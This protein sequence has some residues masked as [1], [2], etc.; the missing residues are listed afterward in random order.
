MIR[1]LSVS[2]SR[3]DIG[4]LFPIWQS[5]LSF[6]KVELHLLMTGMHQTE[7]A[8]PDID[9]PT[10]VKVHFGGADL[11]GA[12][13]KVAAAAMAS[14]TNATADL[15]AATKPDV[16]LVVGDRLDML[17]AAMASLPFNLPMVHL[18][19]GEV[20]E[21]A[22]DN[23]IRHAISK[24][25]HWHCVATNGARKFLLAIGENADRIT[26]TGAPGLD[27]LQAAPRISKANFLRSTGLP[28]SAD[29]WLV[30]VHAETNSPNPLLPIQAV[31][32]ALTERPAPVLFTAPNSDPGGSYIR[33]QIKEFCTTRNDLI[34]IDTLGSDLY[35]NALRHAALMLGNSS[36]GIIE[37]GLFGLP[38]INVGDRQLGRESD[39]NVFNV[40]SEG[41]AIIAALD[42]LKANPKRFRNQSIYGDGK[43]GP[44][45][46][47]IL[48]ELNGL[49]N[50]LKKTASIQ[51]SMP[52]S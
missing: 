46:A 13:G 36:S 51:K 38:V 14:I 45:V 41:S 47:E 42:K 43:S 25:A 22:V 4:I 31:L 32:K 10:S 8:S 9:L 40:P 27:M 30:T 48:V 44:R 34:F 18:H 6:S 37:A 19:G 2:S 52:T 1:I 11:G 7:G 29:F 17:P 35:P 20:T 39:V 26:V 15:V 49:P 5:L 28:E 21:G 23:Q 50:I 24:L 33:Q 12:S 3:A 16:M